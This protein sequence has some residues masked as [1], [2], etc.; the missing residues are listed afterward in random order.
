[1][2]D[3]LR[4]LNA[5][6]LPPALDALDDRVLCLLAARRREAA[7]MRGMMALVA[8]ISLGGGVIAGSVFAP[9]AVAASLL[10]PLI[11]ASPLDPR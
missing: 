9:P 5:A 7:A 10:T 6:E 4:I 1:M 11:P 3:E 8:V 2:D